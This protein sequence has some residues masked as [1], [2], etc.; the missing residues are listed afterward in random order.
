MAKAKASKKRVVSKA[1]VAAAARTAVREWPR[2]EI[3]TKGQIAKSRST[4]GNQYGKT[5]A[6]KASDYLCQALATV[7][8]FA[9][10]ATAP[11]P[12]PM[13]LEFSAP[14]PKPAEIRK[15]AVTLAG[16]AE[17]PHPALLR[18]AR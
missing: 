11:Q 12:R 5:F 1:G 7:Q 8:S 17:A 15:R 14:T 18:L 16:A 2:L 9:V 4:V 13:I 6:S 3:F 10:E